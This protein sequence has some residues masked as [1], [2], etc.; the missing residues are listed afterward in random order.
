MATITRFE[1][2]DAWKKGRELRK[3]VY[4]HSKRGELSPTFNYPRPKIPG[5]GEQLQTCNLKLETLV[6]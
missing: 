3:A 1:D 5:T 6:G 2:I 4:S